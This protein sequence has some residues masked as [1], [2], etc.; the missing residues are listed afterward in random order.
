MTSMRGLQVGDF[1]HDR[2]YPYER[3]KIVKVLKTRIHVMW[4]GVREIEVYDNTHQHFLVK[5]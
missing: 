2:C 3:G 1:V 5:E 4:I